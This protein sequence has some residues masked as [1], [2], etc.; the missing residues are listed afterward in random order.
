MEVV[1]GLGA[2]E[3]HQLVGVAEF[4]GKADAGGQVAAQ[5]HD[6]ADAGPDSVQDL[7]D[8]PRHTSSRCTTG[9]RGLVAFLL[10]L[11][12]GLEG[13]FV[14]RGA[15]RAEGD[16][17]LGQSPASFWRTAR[18]LSRALGGLGRETRCLEEEGEEQE[19]MTACTCA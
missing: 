6:A 11:E 13:A 7:A 16:R 12:D 18:S 9:G 3:L 10:D 2:D 17:E 8:V 1:A 15:A 14:L 4:A 5:G 19:V